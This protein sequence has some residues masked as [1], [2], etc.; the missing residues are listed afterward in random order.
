MDSISRNREFPKTR[1]SLIKRM[2]DDTDRASR[3]EALNDF[4][5]DYLP[6]LRAHIGTPG[7]AINLW[8]AVWLKESL[9]IE[10]VPCNRSKRFVNYSRSFLRVWAISQ[11]W[12]GLA[13]SQT[14]GSSSE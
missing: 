10:S 3:S 5:R 8:G 13:V 9:S 6:V 14:S 11:R 7:M 1:W 12:P 4:F 2:G